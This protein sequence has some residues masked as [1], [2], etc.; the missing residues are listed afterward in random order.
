MRRHIKEIVEGPPYKLLEAV[1]E[2]IAG[3]ILQGDA[4]VRAVE[5]SIAKPHVAVGG[6]VESLGALSVSTASCLA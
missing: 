2:T 1:A 6:V 3:R 5:V 4:R